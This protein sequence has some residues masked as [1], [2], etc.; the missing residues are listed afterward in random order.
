MTE[1]VEGDVYHYCDDYKG[2]RDGRSIRIIGIEETR[3]S[4]S[5][6]KVEFEFSDTDESSSIGVDAFEKDLDRGR[7]NP[8]LAE[9]CSECTEGDNQ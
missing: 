4:Y 5:T 3:S 1:I 2:S 7:F 8:G 6:D 9:N